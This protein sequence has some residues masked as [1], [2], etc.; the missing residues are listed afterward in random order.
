MHGGEFR[1]WVDVPGIYNGKW[2]YAVYED[3]RLR[4]GKELPDDIV[5]ARAKHTRYVNMYRQGHQC[6]E[7]ADQY[8]TDR[9]ACVRVEFEEGQ[10]DD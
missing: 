3:G 6:R 10:L 9:I 2:S 7:R 4:K 8:S 1:D 5:N